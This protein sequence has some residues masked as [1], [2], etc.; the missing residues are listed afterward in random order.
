MQLNHYNDLTD[1]SV[2]TPL[3][4]VN[5]YNGKLYQITSTGQ[6]GSE[7]K[8]SS[9]PTLNYTTPLH[10]FSN[11]AKTYTATKDCY[12]VGTVAHGAS[13]SEEIISINDKNITATPAST[14]EFIFL[15]LSIGDKVVGSNFNSDGKLHVF[16]EKS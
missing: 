7:I 1:Y 8:M 3:R 15:K 9:Y 14:T 5:Y 6:R 11:S 12:L 13:G 10:S 4:N 2:N 16:G